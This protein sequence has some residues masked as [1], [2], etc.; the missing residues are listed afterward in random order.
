MIAVAAEV[1]AVPSPALLEAATEVSRKVVQEFAASV[2]A[3]VY[4]A[5]WRAE[6]FRQE[7]FDWSVPLSSIARDSVDDFYRLRRALTPSTAA[8]GDP[9]D[10]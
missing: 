3:R 7:P 6:G 8:P 1:R 4:E 5:C 10:G 9:T 2:A